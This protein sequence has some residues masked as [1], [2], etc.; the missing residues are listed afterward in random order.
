MVCFLASGML[1]P[2]TPAQAQSGNTSWDVGFAAGVNAYTGDLN[3]TAL[4]RHIHGHGGFIVRYELTEMYAVRLNLQGGGLRGAYDSTRHHLPDIEPDY[5]FH[6]GFV[7]LDL[8]VDI[9]FLPFQVNDFQTRRVRS[10]WIAPYVTA[11]LGIQYVFGGEF[12]GFLPI[13]CGVKFAVG[14]RW[15]L[16]PEI[17]FLKTFSDRADGY[18]N[19]PDHKRNVFLHNRDWI[20]QVSIT[21]TYRL[22]TGWTTC[23]TY[24]NDN[25]RSRY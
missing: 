25:E 14:D 5:K 22:L 21:V 8:S 2:L 24:M 15:T 13:G 11:G 20:S 19:W 18:K 6:T 17:R 16:A 23:P 3:M 10:G 12:T 9:H 1:V 7:D 4:P